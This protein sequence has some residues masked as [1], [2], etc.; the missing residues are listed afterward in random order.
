M[1]EGFNQIPIIKLWHL[2]LVPLQGE[3]T[4]ELAD[5]LTSEVLDRIYRDGSAGPIIDITA[6]WMGGSHPCPLLSQL[7][8]GGSLMG[9][10]TVISRLKAEIALTLQTMGGQPGGISPTL[11]LADA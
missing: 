5:R 11:P 4:D 10:R 9:A 1:D 6:L 8:A 3:L 2:L 7:S